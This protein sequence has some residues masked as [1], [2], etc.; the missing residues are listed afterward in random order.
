MIEGK[1]RR[2]SEGGDERLVLCFDRDEQGL[3]RVS[4]APPQAEEVPKSKKCPRSPFR[5]PRSF[6]GR[7]LLKL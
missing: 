1:D 7:S 2:S 5:L 4:Y 3:F 6:N